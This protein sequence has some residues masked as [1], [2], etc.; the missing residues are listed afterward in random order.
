MDDNTDQQQSKKDSLPWILLGLIILISIAIRAFI[1]FRSE[2]MPGVNGMYYPVQVR[3]LLED[4]SL[5]FSDF[6]F[7][8]Y[9]E[10]GV[11]KLLF[12]FKGG[13]LSDSILLAS[14]LVDSV[15]YPFIAIPAFLLAKS[16]I[17]KEKSRYLPLL[18]PAFVATSLFAFIMMADM[19][20]NS[21]GL[22][23]AMFYIYFLYE[24]INKRRLEYYLLAGLSFL[25][26]GLTHLGGLGLILAFSATLLFF[27]A[28]FEKKRRKAVFLSAVVVLIFCGLVALIIFLFDPERLER[29][30]GII[31]SPLEIF[32]DSAIIAFF[33]G[34]STSLQQDLLNIIIAHI[35]AVFGIVLLIRKWKSIVG[36]ERSFFLTSIILTLFLASP[37]L[38]TEWANRLNIMAYIPMS[39]MLI[40][41]FRYIL[42]RWIKT[43]LAALVLIV[44]FFSV[45]DMIGMR[46]G[47]C[48][49]KESHDDLFKLKDVIESPDSSLVIARHGLE[50]WAA[51]ILETDV[52]QEFG[53]SQETWEAYED[54]YYLKQL[55]GQ[56]D[57]GPQGPGGAAFPEVQI[58]ESAEV[59]Y[60][61]EYFVLARATEPPEFHSGPEGPRDFPQEGPPRRLSEEEE[62]GMQL[63]HGQCNGRGPVTLGTS[64]MKE[65]DFAFIIPYGLMIGAHVTPID[66][67][68]FSPTIFSSPRDTYE[69]R[70][71]ADGRIVDIQHRVHPPSEDNPS[72]TDEY[73]LVFTHT[74]TFFT[75]YDLLT[76]LAS[77]IKAE[78]EKEARDNYASVDIP[79]TEGQL[80]GRIGGQTLDFAVWNTEITLEG[81]VVP[82]HYDS[83]AWKIHTVN[84]YDYYSEELKTLLT[85]KNLRV[86]EPIAG[87]IDYDIDGKLAGNWFLE[88][89]GGYGGGGGG[90][91]YW[92]THLSIVYNHIDPSAIIV[93]IGD[94]NGESQQYG[95]R[96]NF[97]DPA[98]IGVASGLIKYELVQFDYIQPDG[99]HWDRDS[100]VQGLRVVEASELG[101]CVLFEMIEERKVKMEGFPDQLCSGISGFSSEAK[102]YER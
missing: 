98:E 92:K 27:L 65:E 75:Y 102:F 88:G 24:S 83:E 46:G 6:P 85:A 33:S 39:V 95:V 26:T 35:F 28:I 67:Q 14:K 99:Q 89:S 52:G 86:V 34:E 45:P 77:D 80:I 93:S 91:D 51:W 58:P 57:F 81:F 90:F 4:G 55:K 87:K 56:A 12:L 69:V 2:L 60:Q 76:S 94:F 41:F 71:M 16:L 66:H 54:I 47:A 82:E 49:S 32:E 59:V 7:I 70:A 21:I 31:T 25:L 38:G 79:V 18:I 5:G 84:P 19:Q 13:E 30:T 8:F 15:L 101:G 11:A 96:G 44:I 61:D 3:S 20:K 37:L 74:C 97:P 40:F 73:R 68:Y 63:S 72:G 36:F 1:N 29:L 22:L 17:P 53:M 10:A 50:W 23:W 48:I 78:F 64:P 43:I 62:K 100:L 9:L 42:R